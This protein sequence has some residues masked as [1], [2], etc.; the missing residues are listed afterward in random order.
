M[1]A[2][3]IPISSPIAILQEVL[4]SIGLSRNPDTSQYTFAR[5]NLADLAWNHSHI[6]YVS[7][8]NVHW[9]VSEIRDSPI[10]SGTS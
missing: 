8:A 5:K 10:E 9:E 3:P 7:L 2:I 1:A 6:D 4:D